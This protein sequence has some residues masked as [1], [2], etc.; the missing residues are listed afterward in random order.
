MH[1]LETDIKQTDADRIMDQWEQ[2]IETPMDDG[3]DD[4][5]D[6]PRKLKWR[7]VEY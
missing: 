4:D 5:N 7:R 2:T 6:D 1:N 3:H